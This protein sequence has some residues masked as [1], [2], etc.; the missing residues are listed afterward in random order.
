M[1][2]R[3]LKILSDQKLLP[4]LNSVALPF[5]EHC[6]TIKQYRLKFNTSSSRSKA[7]LELVHSNVWQAPVA[8]L[9]GAKYFVSFINDYSRRC[10]VYPIKKKADVFSVFKAYK[11]RVELESEKKIKCLRSD[12]GGEYTDDEFLTFCKQECIKRQLSTAY[13]P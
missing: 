3:G 7:I 1:S 12:N 13:T 9:G 4:G 11:A 6:V 5:C 2:E 10:W 8:S